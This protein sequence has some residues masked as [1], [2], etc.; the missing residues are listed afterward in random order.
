MAAYFRVSSQAHDHASQQSAI[1]RAAARGDVIGAWYMEK[2]SA[3][4]MDRAELQ[5]LRAEGCAGGLREL[6]VSRTS[7]S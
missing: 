3:K 7:A 6:Y 2:K 4:S 1:E 5:S